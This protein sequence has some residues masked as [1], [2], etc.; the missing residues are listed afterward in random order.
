[1]K[2]ERKN[3]LIEVLK[4]MAPGTLLREGLDN[5]L[6]AK[7]G[8]LVVLDD[9]KEILS[10]TDGGFKINAE[11]TPSYLYE[12]AKMD[13]AI[14]VSKNLKTI[15]L[16]NT[17]LLPSSSINTYETGTRHRTAQ[18]VARQ[19]G[20]TVIAISQRR[21]II[22][23][24]KGDFKYILRESAEVLAKA[25]QA[26]HTLE[27]YTSVFDR[28]LTN[29]NIIE[30]SG[31]VTLFDITVIVQKIEL[32]KRIIKEIEIYIYELG[33]EGRL[34]EMQLNELVKDTE[35]EADYILKDYCET[36][37]NYK[38]V[39]KNLS[40]LTEKELVELNN[41]A[42]ILGYSNQ[43][44]TEK[45]VYPKGYRVLNKI[46]RIPASVID[47]IIKDF[48]ELRFV[49]DATVED[50]DSVEGIGEVRAKFIREWLNKFKEQYHI[51]KE[52]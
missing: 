1:M 39:Y 18:R 34:L 33:N 16:A 44:L 23:V 10:I 24:Y 19:T 12:L 7:T 17:Q 49:L 30:I 51:E 2:E 42:K 47:N 45:I 28:S 22:S 14:I 9:S 8:G 5:I 29:L 13:G 32:M 48:K 26:L 38:N 50:L 11:Y 6:R 25:N 15:L 35:E 4:M 43:S 20:T 41:I 31:T 46:Y 27:K 37:D 3:K 21:N 40:K 52:I 36:E